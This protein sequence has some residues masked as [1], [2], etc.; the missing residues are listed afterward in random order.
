MAWKEGGTID[1]A[2]HHFADAPGDCFNLVH[3]A[4]GGRRLEHPPGVVP[5]AAAG[6]GYG[7]CPHHR[8][9]ERVGAV[10]GARRHPAPS[11]AEKWV[12]V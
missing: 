4:F 5:K 11:E 8:R 6:C 3:V 9:P 2:A 7:R 1:D 12:N 10:H